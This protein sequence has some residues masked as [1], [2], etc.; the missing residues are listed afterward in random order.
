[1]ATTRCVGAQGEVSGRSPRF[2]LYAR[3]RACVCVPRTPGP[4]GGRRTLLPCM[5]LH[6]GF[7]FRAHPHMPD[8]ALPSA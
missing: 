4:G 6:P 2:F 7:A 8:M 1:M 5:D 3:G